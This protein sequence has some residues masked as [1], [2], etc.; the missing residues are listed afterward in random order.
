MQEGVRCAE[1]KGKP[2]AIAA[3]HD[4]PDDRANQRANNGHGKAGAPK[5]PANGR[6]GIKITS[7]DKDNLDNNKIVS[8]GAKPRQPLPSGEKVG[9]RCGDGGAGMHPDDNVVA[10]A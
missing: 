8:V 2:P 9:V 7:V 4:D 5:A 10:A 1:R 3:K 6:H